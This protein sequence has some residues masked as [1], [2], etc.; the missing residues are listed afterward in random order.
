M[1]KQAYLEQL[2]R[3]LKGVPEKEAA[4][5]LQYYQECFEEAGEDGAEALIARL[6]SPKQ[7]A[8]EV[9]AQSAMRT[10]EEKPATPKS[11]LTALWAVLLALFVSPVTLPVAAI[12]FALAITVLSVVLSVLVVFFSL[13]LALA[14]AGLAFLVAG[15]A[16]CTAHVPTGLFL[17]GSGLLLK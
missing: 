9:K 11:A 10:M 17:L 5:C 14:A 4:E 7:A 8:A 3:E 6:G 15:V 16:V 13:A 12:G 1:D 2:G